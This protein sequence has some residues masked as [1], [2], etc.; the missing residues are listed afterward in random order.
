M[1]FPAHQLRDDIGAGGSPRL[2]SAPDGRDRAPRL[3][4][5]RPRFG[6]HRSAMPC[7]THAQSLL[8]SHIDIADRQRRQCD[9]CKLPLTLYAMTALKASTG[10]RTPALRPLLLGLGHFPPHSA[11]TRS[12]PSGWALLHSPIY[13]AE[14]TPSQPSPSRGRVSRSAA[15]PGRALPVRGPRCKAVRRLLPTR[16]SCSRRRSG[17]ACSPPGHAR[18]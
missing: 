1:R 17:C 8:N 4:S 12:A 2:G 13:A 16:G 3:R 11:G 5:G 9:L 10:N 14:A 7:R 6:L 15:R 18:C